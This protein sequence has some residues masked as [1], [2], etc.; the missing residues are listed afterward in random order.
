MQDVFFRLGGAAAGRAATSLV[1]DSSQVILDDIW[2]WRADHGDGVGWTDNSGDTGL[3]VEGDDVTAYGLFVEHYEK[4][5]VIWNG[6]DG[7]DIFFENE[8]PYDPPS[9]TAWRA[10]PATDGYPAFLIT[11]R[12]AGFHGYGMAS[13]SFFDRGVP[14]QATAAFQ[15]AGRP[16]ANCTI[17][18]RSSSARPGPAASSTW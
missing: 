6:R 1:I 2:A 17:C 7:T 15:T 10:S 18:S 4:D 5:E 14:I 12:A 11:R 16:A 3:D 13:Y 8:M 9:Q